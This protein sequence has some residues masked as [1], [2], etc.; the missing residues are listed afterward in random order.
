MVIP[1]HNEERY[2]PTGLAA[3]EVAA[4]VLGE[5]VEVVVVA[6]RCTDATAAL[7]E[8]WGAVVVEDDARSIGAVRN[9]GAAVASGELLVTVDADCRVAPGSLRA[10]SVLL[11]SGV[12]VGGGSRIVPER[13]SPGIVATYAVMELLVG[14]SRL[15]GGMF[16]CRRDDFDAVGGFD[17]DL[18]VGEDLD[19]ARRLRA[20]GRR[21]GRRFMKI[22]S[23]P[24]EASCRKFDQFGDWHM[25]AMAAQLGQIARAARGVDTTWVDR[26]FFDFND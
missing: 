23:A 21:S 3:I 1:A 24:V 25:F 17:A 19:F 14:A 2:L 10:A 6:N 5:P 9:A 8:A 7:A 26:Y 12:V 13:R 16:W 15:A 4:E 20:H 11:D 18:L 22:R